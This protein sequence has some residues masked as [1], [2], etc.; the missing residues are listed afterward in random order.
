MAENSIFWTTGATGDGATAYTQAE[1]IAWMR[2]MFI[3]DLTAKG[4]FTY[5]NELEVTKGGGARELDVADGAALVAGFFYTNSATVTKTLTHP[6]IGTTGWRL[7]LR[8]DWAAQTVR[9]TLIESSDGVAA[10][11]AMTQTDG[12]T[13]DI[14]LASG[15]ITT[16]DVV[17]ITDARS[18][19]T[20]NVRVANG[21]IRQSAALSVIGRSAN[22]TGDVA[23]IAAASD[24]QVLRR[25]GTGI[26][27]G[28][29]AAAGLGADCVNGTKIADDSIDSEHY[30]DGSI[31]LAH[32]SADCVDDTKVGNRVPQFYRRQGGNA[33]DWSVSGTTDYTPTTVRMQSGTNQTDGSGARNI[34]FPVAFSNKPQV[35]AL[36]VIDAAAAP[37]VTNVTAT[38]CT[39][40]LWSDS[41]DKIAFG[42]FFWLAIGPE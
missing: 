14:P 8:A 34:T 42:T 27:F 39:I 15:T 6:T 36:A 21:N 17:A 30:V 32:L 25:S 41:G 20:P 33:T 24:G 13:Y 2:A 11:P 1:V 31:D 12:T 26:G 35:F 18:Y 19:I 9:I 3:S 5:G 38:G 29:V 37:A 7:V 16:G 10:V 22:S 4:I 28:T 23:D 40:K